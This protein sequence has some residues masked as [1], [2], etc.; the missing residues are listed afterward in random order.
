MLYQGLWNRMSKKDLEV[1]MV[2]TKNEMNLKQQH[3]EC[4]WQRQPE[5]DWHPVIYP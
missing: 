3:P 1:E 5:Y 4:E 2:W